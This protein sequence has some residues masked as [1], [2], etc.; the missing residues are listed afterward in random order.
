MNNYRIFLAKR[1]KEL[2]E[3]AGW[4]QVDLATHAGT[5]STTISAIE[6]GRT[7]TNLDTIGNIAECLGVN[8]AELFNESKVPAPRII[9]QDIPTAFQLATEDLIRRTASEL[10]DQVISKIKQRI[11]ASP[12]DPLI[13]LISQLDET[14]RATAIKLFE[15][16]FRR[17]RKN[18][19]SGSS[20]NSA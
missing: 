9:K 17:T 8:L 4:S 11:E 12:V 6:T 14:E 1:V 20:S 7:S 16:H 15:T 13:E 18:S 5:T 19:K 3:A 2:R 10:S